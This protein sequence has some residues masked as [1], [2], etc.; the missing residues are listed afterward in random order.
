MRSP[1]SSPRLSDEV[2]SLLSST[3]HT[4]YIPNILIPVCACV[5]V[6]AHVGCVVTFLFAVSL[7]VHHVK[8]WWYKITTHKVF[9]ALRNS[10]RANEKRSP[11]TPAVLLTLR[12]IRSESI[13]LTIKMPPVMLSSHCSSPSNCITPI[14]RT[15]NFINSHT[16]W[17]VSKSSRQCRLPAISIT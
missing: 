8:T 17:H 12:A 4:S 3:W 9:H 6:G 11:L 10:T 5:S 16:A 15:H 7:F 14:E 2:S 13:A 1:V